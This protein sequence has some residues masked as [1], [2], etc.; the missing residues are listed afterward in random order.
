M[1]APDQLHYSDGSHRWIP[2]WPEG[3]EDRDLGWRR[4]V[5]AHIEEDHAPHAPRIPQQLRRRA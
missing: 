5:E 2:P 1:N 3:D 4:T